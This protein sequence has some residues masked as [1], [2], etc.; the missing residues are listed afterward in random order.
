MIVR[1]GSSPPTRWATTPISRL[2]V[3]RF[4]S[5]ERTPDGSLNGTRLIQIANDHLLERQPPARMSSGAIPMLQQQR[6]TPEPT[7]PSPTIP[8]LTLS[9]ITILN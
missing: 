4:R 7:V 3:I 5:V 9:R 1:A 8:T 6:A 2:S